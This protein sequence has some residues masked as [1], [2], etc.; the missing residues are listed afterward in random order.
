MRCSIY[1]E[2][3]AITTDEFFQSLADTTR[4]RCLL[5]L[6]R[7]GKL[8][9]CELQ[10]ALDQPQPKISRHLAMLRSAGIVSDRRD[11]QWIHYRLHPGLPAWAQQILTVA[12]RGS[13]AAEPYTRDHRRLKAMID[14]PPARRCA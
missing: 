3:M 14:R 10:H 4:L 7:E 2:P 13:A 12:A 8:C 1:F 5:L 11:G 6:A 9:V